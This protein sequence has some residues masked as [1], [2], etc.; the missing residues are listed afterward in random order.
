MVVK[1]GVHGSFPLSISED[2]AQLSVSVNL[3]GLFFSS[4]QTLLCEGSIEQCS[5]VPCF[6]GQKL[7]A[8]L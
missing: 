4:L 1:A 8:L 2:L 7:H 6:L 3:F 5:S